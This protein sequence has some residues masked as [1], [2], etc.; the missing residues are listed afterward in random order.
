MSLTNDHTF[1]TSAAM[2]IST[3]MKSVGAL[4]TCVL[5]SRTQNS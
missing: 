3:S 1:A 5:L 2:A 4:M